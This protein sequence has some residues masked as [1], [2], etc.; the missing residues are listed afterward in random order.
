MT[1]KHHINRHDASLDKHHGIR[2]A[3]QD[4]P[5]GDVMPK[6]FGIWQLTA[7]FRLP[8]AMSSILWGLL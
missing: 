6:G 2:P 8:S 4:L 7:S 3:Q 1:A 5:A